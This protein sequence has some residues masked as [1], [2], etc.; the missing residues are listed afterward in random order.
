LPHQFVPPLAILDALRLLVY[1][2]SLPSRHEPHRPRGR[3]PLAATQGKKTS[4]IIL[5]K[6]C[7]TVVV[8]QRYN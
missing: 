5:L 8:E 6:E 1:V 7:V 4:A 3:F 2:F